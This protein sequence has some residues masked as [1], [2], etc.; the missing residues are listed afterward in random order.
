MFSGI[1]EKIGRVSDVRDTP[2]ERT[3]A[4]SLPAGWKLADGESV[5]IE[6]VCST[7]QKR[8]KGKFAVVYMHETLR[9]TT[10]GSLRLGSP[11]NLERSLRLNGLISGHLVQGHVDATGEIRKIT[12]DGSARIYEFEVP[13][14]LRRYVVEKGSIAI[15]GISLTVKEVT[16]KGCTVSL[17]EFTLLHTTLGGKTVGDRVNLEVDLIAKYVENLFKK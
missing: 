15:D 6:G 13:A 9:R 12:K 4:I 10:L 1:V 5:S 2:N 7:V 14:R 16:R 11:V 3:M 17:L 8:A